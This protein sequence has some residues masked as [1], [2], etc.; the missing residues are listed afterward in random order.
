MI[1][2]SLKILFKKIFISFK[3]TLMYGLSV[4]GLIFILIAYYLNND[5]PV[6]N[7][8]TSLTFQENS[9]GFSKYPKFRIIGGSEAAPHSQPWVVSLRSLT[10]GSPSDHI[11]AGALI[12]D[13]FV[14]TA[15]HCV[16]DIDA[17]S[18][19]VIVGL[20]SVNDYQENQVYYAENLWVH[21]EYTGPQSQQIDN[22]VAIIKLS[23]NVEMSD[24]VS[25]VC[26]PYD[27]DEDLIESFVEFYGWGNMNDGFDVSYPEYL[28]TTELKVANDDPICAEPEQNLNH[29][30]CTI[31]VENSNICFG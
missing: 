31:G 4:T 16:Q 29:L 1:N 14:L 13:L 11:C 25:V 10:S 28:Q 19:A 5:S 17:S 12:S 8:K 15:A 27:G 18:L 20:H 9:C 3:R 23:K 7:H 2:L 30:F 6:S 24:T 22:D 21:E 26:L